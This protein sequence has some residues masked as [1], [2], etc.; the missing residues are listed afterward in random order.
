[1]TSSLSM[2]TAV[3]L[4][5]LAVQIADAK[6]GFEDCM[7]HFINDFVPHQPNTHVE[8][9]IGDSDDDGRGYYATSYD[10]RMVNPAWSANL[11]T[12]EEAQNPT[13][14]RSGGFHE[15]VD[16]T[17]IG[18][19]QAPVYSQV[20]G[21]KYNRG[22]LNPSHVMS[23]TKLAENSTYT[24]SNAAPQSAYFNQKPWAELERKVMEWVA[25][26]ATNL[27]VITGIAYNDREE[28]QRPYDDIAIP[29]YY[30]K[31]ICDPLSGSSAAF[32]GHNDY[33]C[34]GTYT[35]V[36]VAAVEKLI[37]GP[38]FDEVCNPTVVDPSY[39]FSFPKNLTQH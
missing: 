10:S 25:A 18:V 21:D 7:K 32:I 24:M 39:W 33:S 22:H 19:W 11:V 9:C 30:W 14:G 20:F 6:I 8:L 28:V 34:A 17:R 36:P 13:V 3:L 27:Y 1:M 16:L 12:V 38:L 26:N 37:G 23:Y 29:D 15:N 35:F 31:A 2:L 4:A 5:V